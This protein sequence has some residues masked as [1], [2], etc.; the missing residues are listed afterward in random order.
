M[1][2]KISCVVT[3]LFSAYFN[4]VYVSFIIVKNCG[5]VMGFVILAVYFRLKLLFLMGFLFFIIGYINLWLTYAFSR[6]FEW[7]FI[8]MVFNFNTTW[9]ITI[10]FCH[11]RKIL[12]LPDILILYTISF[13][14]IM[15][16][17]Y[18]YKLWIVWDQSSH[19]PCGTPS[20]PA[21]PR[22]KHQMTFWQVRVWNRG[23]LI[24]Q[25]MVC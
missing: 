13:F 23:E 25:V 10:H 6:I 5:F 22:K 15:F 3:Y 16:Q 20:I 4:P 21:V 18:S 1:H 19:E 9:N 2:R 7:I 12:T 17:F 14:S 11:T 8:S 24:Y